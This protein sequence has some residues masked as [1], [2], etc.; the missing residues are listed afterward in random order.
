[1]S[2]KREVIDIC[3]A[4]PADWWLDYID[5]QGLAIGYPARLSG[6][7]NDKS[8]V[9][10][11][12]RGMRE[13][14]AALRSENISRINLVCID[15]RESRGF[16]PPRLDTLES[17]AEELDGVMTF[18][19]GYDPANGQRSYLEALQSRHCV[20]I[21]LS[22]F[23]AG[24]P[25]SDP[26]WTECLEF[27]AA[28]NLAVWVHSS[29]HFSSFSGYDIGHPR[30]LDDVLRRY[31]GLVVIAG[32]ACWPWV[33]DG[34][35]IALRHATL[36]FDISTFP[37]RVLRRPGWESLL[38]YGARELSERVLF[39]SSWLGSGQTIREIADELDGLNLKGASVDLWACENAKRLFASLE[40]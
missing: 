4:L 39:G 27:A 6:A 20:G 9:P 22:P 17:A 21:A 1:L 23:I 35:S 3:S 18:M 8:T 29:I 15:G 26:C 38:Y 13:Y 16:A 5:R 10:P 24:V 28:R 25:I 2:D 37:P 33:L 32:H 34:C 11:Q 36:Y 40:R 19:I 12:Y 31:P 14:A 30:H 7:R